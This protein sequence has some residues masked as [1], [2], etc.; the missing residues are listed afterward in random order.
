MK[1]SLEWDLLRYQDHGK[2]RNYVKSL[3]HFCLDHPALYQLDHD[4]EGFTWINNISANENM[5]VFVRRSKKPEETLLVVCNFSPLVYEKHKIGVPFE[6]RYKEIFNSDSEIFGGSDVL[7]RR[8]KRSK[9]SECD[10]LENSIEITVP[11][12]GVTIFSCTKEKAPAKA[13][14]PAREKAPVKEKTPAKVKAQ[15]T[16]KAPAKK[17]SAGKKSVPEEVPV[18]KGKKGRGKKV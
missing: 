17:A 2:M 12:M 10:G 15:A 18:V 6:G 1:K 8:A 16:E 11:P 14:T 3:N 9:K 13:K 7:N 5:L 4:P